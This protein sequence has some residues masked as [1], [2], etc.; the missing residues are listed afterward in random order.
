VRG[1]YAAYRLLDA[2]AVGRSVGRL[3]STTTDL[4]AAFDGLHRRLRECGAWD[5]LR[6]VENKGSKQLGR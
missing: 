5:V 1:Y 6:D 4:E 3:N 2:D